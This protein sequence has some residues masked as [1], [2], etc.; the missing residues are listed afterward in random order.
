MK[1]AIIGYGKMG[2]TIEAIAEKK[3]FEVVVIIGSEEDWKTSEFKLKK[4]DVAIEFTTPATV[5]GNV[6]RCF[7]LNIPVVCGTT[8]WEDQLE[9]VKNE[10]H[11]RKATFFY[12]S[13]FSLGVNVFFLINRYLAGL[14]NPLNQYDVAIEEIHHIHKMDAPSGTAKTLANDVIKLLD[15]KTHWVNHETSIKSELPIISHR[16]GEVAGTH[17]IRYF[18]E[19]DEIEIKHT[20][21]SRLGFAYGALMASDWVKGKTGFFT[22]DDLMR[23]LFPKITK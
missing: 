13:N 5:A 2:K 17:I 23:S 18:S 21:K 7:D 16:V 6:R 22:M 8:G 14:M 9:S 19:I 4:A 3:G 11:S 12:A 10:C 15:Q 1:L 20:A